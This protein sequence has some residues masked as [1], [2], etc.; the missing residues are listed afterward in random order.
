MSNKD[1]FENML[2]NLFNELRLVNI[3]WNYY[4]NIIDFMY[5]HSAESINTNNKLNTFVI[6]KMIESNN[7]DINIIPLTSHMTIAFKYNTG[8]GI[9]ITQF[10]ILPSIT[11]SK[12]NILDHNARKLLIELVVKY[13]EQKMSEYKQLYERYSSINLD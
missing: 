9:V 4:Y 12:Q 2:E 1:F 3:M 11:I 10:T 8:A 7:F 5:V 13:T 6:D